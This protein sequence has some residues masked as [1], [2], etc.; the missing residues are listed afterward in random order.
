M[1]ANNCIS[2]Y[3]RFSPYQLVLGQNSNLSSVLTD[4]L[5]ALEGKSEQDSVTVYQN[6]LHAARKAFVKAETSERI[7]R[8]LRHKVRVAEESFQ[9]GDKIFHK[10]NYD[11][12]WRGPTKVIG[13]DD[14]IVYAR[15]SDQLGLSK[16]V[17]NFMKTQISEIMKTLFRRIWK[18][19]DKDCTQ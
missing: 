5:P 6:A 3:S 19:T 10:R 16:S 8:A 4:D 15:H 17:K 2:N 18:K 7:R 9:S 13:Q 11:N 12:R 1:N 14:K